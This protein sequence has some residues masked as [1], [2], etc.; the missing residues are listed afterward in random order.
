VVSTGKAPQLG[1]AALLAAGPEIA[2]EAALLRWSP[3][4][5]PARARSCNATA[6]GPRAPPLS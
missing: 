3:H 2:R 6:S 4:S 5:A 1:A